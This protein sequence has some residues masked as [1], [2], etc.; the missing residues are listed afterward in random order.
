MTPQIGDSAPDFGPETTEVTLEA[1]N[2][3]LLYPRE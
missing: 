2:H 1:L 3:R